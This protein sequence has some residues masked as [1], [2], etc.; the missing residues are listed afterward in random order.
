MSKAQLVYVVTDDDDPNKV[1]AICSHDRDAYSLTEDR[2]NS[3]MTRRAFI[4]VICGITEGV[5]TITIDLRSPLIC[6]EPMPGP[7][8]DGGV[9]GNSSRHYRR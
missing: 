9:D 6:D 2:L 8:P 4:P 5:F 7:I 3:G 1:W